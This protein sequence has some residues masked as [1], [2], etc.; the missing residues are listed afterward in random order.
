MT[1][2][3]H[4]ATFS[5][6]FSL[7]T[8]L[9]F[10]F[11]LCPSDL[12]LLLQPLGRT[13]TFLVFFFVRTTSSC[14]SWL[15]TLFFMISYCFCCSFFW[16]LCYKAEENIIMSAVFGDNTSLYCQRHLTG[17]FLNCLATTAPSLENSE[18][19]FSETSMGKRKYLP[20]HSW[21]LARSIKR[22]IKSKIEPKDFNSLKRLQCSAIER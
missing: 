8:G 3:T 14:T 20:L 19:R 11:N 15:K 2:S 9:S 21:M 18:S 22:T 4:E 13:A 17:D 1:T 16:Q 12:L 7:I 5:F 6:T 10:S